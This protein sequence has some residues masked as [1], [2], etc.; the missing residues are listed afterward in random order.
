MHGVICNAPQ[1]SD[2]AWEEKAFVVFCLSDFDSH[3]L[4]LECLINAVTEQNV[5]HYL[6]QYL[7]PPFIS[8]CKLLNKT[9]TIFP[10]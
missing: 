9:T 6:L 4:L 3:S 7:T 10:L 2:I 8:S 5:T 1:Y